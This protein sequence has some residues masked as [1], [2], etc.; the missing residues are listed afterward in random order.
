MNKLGLHIIGGT[1]TQLAGNPASG[2]PPDSTLPPRLIKLVDAS[3]EYVREIRGKVGAACLIIVRWVESNRLDDG[4]KDWFNRHFVE[5]RNM[6]DP[7][8]AFE[9]PNE[10]PDQ[11]AMRYAVWESQRL[12]L[13]H[14]ANLRSVVGNWSV[15]VP[16]LPT[17]DVYAPMLSLL[18][19]TDFI[20]LHEYWSDHADIANT[21][22]CARWTLCAPL[23]TNQPIVITECGRDVVEG[24]GFAGWQ[25][26]ASPVEFI[27]DLGEYNK[28]LE[29]YPNVLGA[30]VFQVGS[31]DRQWQTYDVS[32]IWPFI[33]AKYTG[34]TTMPPNPTQ[35]IA[36]QPPIHGTPRI[37]QQFA[38]NPA[39]YSPYGL[40]G[41]PGLD[42]AVP[43]GTVIRAPVAGTCY[44][45]S[46]TYTAYGTHLWIKVDG[47]DAWVILGHL[48]RVLCDNREKV[49]PGSI[50]ALSGNTGRST[51]PHLHLGIETREPN[52][53]YHDALDAPYYWQDPEKFTP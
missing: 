1:T 45:G 37:S 41:H 48:S 20:G 49:Q 30:C 43:T 25:R 39:M 3:P 46:E 14:A 7:N 13:M 29:S 32:A 44:V 52:P 47:C 19:P 42:Y 36:L 5:M 17:W 10:I 27:N 18:K 11:L 28:L 22:H 26:S 9:G 53:G 6:T 8:V 50:V 2:S 31:R 24:E 33:T 23:L 40:A 51:G 12:A 21:W 4:A 15:G 34:A 16:D 35:N 38:H